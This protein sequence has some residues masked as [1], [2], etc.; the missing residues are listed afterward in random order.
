[1]YGVKVNLSTPL[2]DRS[3]IPTEIDGVQIRVEVVGQIRP[4]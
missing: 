3:A 2:E 4:R 1:V